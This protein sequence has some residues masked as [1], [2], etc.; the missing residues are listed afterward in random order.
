[1]LR[2]APFT[3]LPTTAL[4][5]CN[6]SCVVLWPLLTASC[7]A[8]HTVRSFCALNS[9]SY[10]S[11][12]FFTAYGSPQCTGVRMWRVG[13]TIWVKITLCVPLEM[14]SPP[15][16]H[17][18]PWRG[19]WSSAAPFTSTAHPWRPW[20]ACRHRS[21]HWLLPTTKPLQLALKQQQLVMLAPLRSPLPPLPHLLL[22]LCWVW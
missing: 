2:R 13:L 16:P 21:C 8:L 7:C 5:T 15:L 14:G 6:A 4:C 3:S 18:R 9:Q 17:Q 22:P 10:P 1:M 11:K 19:S 20:S 12:P